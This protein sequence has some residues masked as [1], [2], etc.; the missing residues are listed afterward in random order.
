[1]KKRLDILM[2]ERGLAVSRTQAQALIMAG[3]VSAEGRRLEKPGLSVDEGLELHIKDQ[4]RFVS[5]AGEKLASVATA[6]Q[7]DFEGMTVLDVGSSTGGFTDFALMSGAVRVYCVDVGTGQLSYKLRQD[8]RVVVMEQTDIRGAKLPELADMAVMDVSFISLTKVLEPT[9]AL[10]KPGEPIVAMVKPQFEAGK[11]I[12]DR[13]R[14]VIPMG[15]VRDGILAELREWMAGR[16]E[17]VGEADSG[18]AGAEGNVE[19]FFLLRA[20]IGR[21]A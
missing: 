11:P 7:L 21:M 5:R 19:R 10:V 20:L 1:M 18:L 8:P 6:L 9:A 12:A 16:F 2:M 13:Y 14:G 15:E 3:Q 4:P 17:I